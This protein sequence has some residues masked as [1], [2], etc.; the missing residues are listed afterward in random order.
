MKK[1]EKI[2][3]YFALTIVLIFWF[4]M[5]FFFS[6][7]NYPLD[8]KSIGN[9]E[10]NLLGQMW[11]ILK[12][13]CIKIEEKLKKKKRMKEKLSYLFLLKDLKKNNMY[14]VK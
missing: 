4:L 10:K 6:S 14:T 9:R 12:K 7:I 3:F 8:V 5:F 1:E 13:V 2:V 11:N